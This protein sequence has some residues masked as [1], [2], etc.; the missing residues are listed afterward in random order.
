MNFKRFKE[1]TEF[2][3]QKGKETDS[4]SISDIVA[5]ERCR[6]IKEFLDDSYKAILTD[7]ERDYIERTIRRGMSTMFKDVLMCASE[8]PEKFGDTLSKV[9]GLDTDE[10]GGEIDE[11]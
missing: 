1:S 4:T 5:M 6:A 8:N 7:D 2:H 10:F 3:V 9:L 11:Q